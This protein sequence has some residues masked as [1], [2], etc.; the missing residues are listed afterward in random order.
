ML[1]LF[2]AATLLVVSAAD[3]GKCAALGATCGEDSKCCFHLQCC[4]DSNVCCDQ[5]CGDP[6]CT[7]PCYASKDVDECFSRNDDKHCSWC[8]GGHIYKMCMDKNIAKQGAGKG[9]PVH[10]WTCFDVKERVPATH[11]IRD[12]M[13]E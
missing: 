8:I 10:G 6:R 13:P 1:R 4:P 7:D 12:H 3:D 11:Q 2:L 9:S 5:P